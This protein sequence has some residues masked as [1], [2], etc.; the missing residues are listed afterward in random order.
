M[1]GS[2]DRL[3][4]DGMLRR[5]LARFS[6]CTAQLESLILPCWSCLADIRSLDSWAA[7]LRREP[8]WLTRQIRQCGVR[9]PRRLLIWL[10]LLNAWPMLQSGRTAGE[11]ALAVGYSAP[12]AFTRSTHQFVGVPPSLADTIPLE[13]LINCAAVDLVA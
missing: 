2:L 8:E 11:V 7:L 1:R 3:L 5:F 13:R 12:P 6:P 9:S 4:N 10:R